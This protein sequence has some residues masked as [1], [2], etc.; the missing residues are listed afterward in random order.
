MRCTEHATAH[1]HTGCA[2]VCCV[3]MTGDS[4]SLHCHPVLN[5]FEGSENIESDWSK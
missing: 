4:V 1:P 5:A 2:V 3:T